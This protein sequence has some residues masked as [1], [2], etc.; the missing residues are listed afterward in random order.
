MFDAP[1]ELL[2]VILMTQRL[3]AEPLEA[4]LLADFCLISGRREERARHSAQ[5]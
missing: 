3:H 5:M 4:R 2:G 1:L